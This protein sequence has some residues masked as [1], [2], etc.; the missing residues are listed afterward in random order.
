M[1][2]KFNNS[3]PKIR[4]FHYFL[5]F[6]WISGIQW[7]KYLGEA[8]AFWGVWMPIMKEASWGPRPDFFFILAFTQSVFKSFKDDFKKLFYKDISYLLS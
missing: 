7:V 5:G 4:I 1:V 3:I 6:I 2:M 8:I